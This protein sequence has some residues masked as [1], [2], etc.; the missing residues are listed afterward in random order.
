MR[1]AQQSAAAQPT[2]PS[3]ARRG[4]LI[5]DSAPLRAGPG[6]GDD[7]RLR[8]TLGRRFRDRMRCRPH[9]CFV[10]P[11]PIK[12]GAAALVL[13]PRTERVLPGLGAT[14]LLSSRRRGPGYRRG[15]LALARRLRR[16]PLGGVVL[17]QHGRV[18]AEGRGPDWSR[19]ASVGADSHSAQRRPRDRCGVCALLSGAGRK[20]GVSYQTCWTASRCKKG[21]LRASPSWPAGRGREA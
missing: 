2:E 14:A 1:A 9:A 20:M 3:H 11:T 7:A 8:R 21:N 13:T 6:F 16:R 4:Y 12:G 5:G 10:T 18:S 15:D 17:F 19:P